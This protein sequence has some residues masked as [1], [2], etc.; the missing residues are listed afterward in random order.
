MPTEKQ[1][2][3]N[4]PC[5]YVFDDVLDAIPGPIGK[6]QMSHILL[7]VNRIMEDENSRSVRSPYMGTHIY[8]EGD[9]LYYAIGGGYRYF[10]EFKTPEMAHHYCSVLQGILML[11]VSRFAMDEEREPSVFPS[12][13]DSPARET[14]WVRGFLNAA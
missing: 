5:E 8:P 14:R 12:R 2:Y 1:G 11:S 10:L 6:L 13:V 9:R 4:D 3:W 7:I